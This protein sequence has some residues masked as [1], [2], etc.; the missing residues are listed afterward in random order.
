MLQRAN[1]REDGTFIAYQTLLQSRNDAKLVKCINNKGIQKVCLMLVS[2]VR[3]SPGSQWFKNPY[4]HI[5]SKTT[6]QK[7][8]HLTKNAIRPVSPV[9][10]KLLYHF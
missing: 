5:S 10:G 7:A 9:F 2:S 8:F 6:G 1:L 3:N 4:F